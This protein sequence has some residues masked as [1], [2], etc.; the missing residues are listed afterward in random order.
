MLI[1]IFIL[2]LFILAET[3]FLTWNKL[4]NIKLASNPKIFVDT[5]TL[6]DGR[7]LGVAKT[8]FITADL[9]IPRSVLRELQLLA[10]GSDNEKRERAR[11]GLDIVRELERVVEVNVDIFADPLDRTPVDN[12]LI[13]LA[14]EYKGS[15][16]TNDYN[17]NKVAT[18]EGVMVLNVN[19]LALTVRGEH[20]PGEEFSV[21]ISSKG[22]NK[23]QGAGYLED[24]TKIIVDGAG[25][26]LN[27]TI[28]VTLTNIHQ[29]PAGKMAFGKIVKTDKII[30]NS[31]KK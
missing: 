19:D 12:R 17:L 25:S 11:F 14:K 10:D 31:R 4:K 1:I 13:D 28:K 22:N 26:K 7:I 3:T 30:K 6:I 5:S 27:K 20:L 15:I 18:A 16:M 29:T 21:R 9:I 24:G 2:T 8:G 23:D